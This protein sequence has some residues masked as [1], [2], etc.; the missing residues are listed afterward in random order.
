MFFMKKRILSVVCALTLAFGSAAALPLG[1]FEQTV[2]T[3][4][5]Q[6]LDLSEEAVYKAMIAF[7]DEYPEGTPW[8]NDD[9]YAW[10][11]GT[12]S[13]GYGCAGFAFMLSDAAF[14]DL[15]ARQFS[16]VDE[17][18]VGDILRINNNTHSVIVLEVSDGYV[19]VAEGNFNYSVHWGRRFSFD[20]LRNI[21]DYGMTRYPEEVSTR[22]KGDLNNNGKIDAS[23]LLQVKSHIKK[24][25]LLE[26]DD[27]KAADVDG[28]G[29]INASDLLKMKA[30]MKGVTPI[31]E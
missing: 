5:A 30:H 17:I 3:A 6:E 27:F 1:H 14:G 2:L 18:R 26:G 16:D 10:K 20:T 12:Y 9:F 25:Q 7:M 4:A 28:N 31:W 29:T 19:T 21:M 24:V 13:G 8:S 11:G 15:E 23:D 22:K